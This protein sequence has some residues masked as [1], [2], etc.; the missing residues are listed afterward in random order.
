MPK[1]NALLVAVLYAGM[2]RVLILNIF[3]KVLITMPG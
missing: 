1:S 2:Q 3:Q